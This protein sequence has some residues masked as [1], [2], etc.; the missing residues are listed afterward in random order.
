MQ[1][2]RQSKILICVI[3]YLVFCSWCRSRGPQRRRMWWAPWPSPWGTWR[4]RRGKCRAG[5]P[6]CCSTEMKSKIIRIK[7]LSLN[8]YWNTQKVTLNIGIIYF[9]HGDASINLRNKCDEKIAY[10]FSYILLHVKLILNDVYRKK[11]F[12]LGKNW[13]SD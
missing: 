8:M 4:P 3:V 13:F 7:L 12:K 10:L 2:K 5:R 11:K 1:I 9:Y 6:T